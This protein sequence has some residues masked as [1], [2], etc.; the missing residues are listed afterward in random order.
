VQY[1]TVEDIV[2]LKDKS[3]GSPRGC[4]FVSYAANAAAEAAIKALDKIVH[5]PGALS[6]ME[7]CPTALQWSLTEKA[8]FNTGF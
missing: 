6:P 7:V 1:G 8:A 4:A 2:I 5:L 3:S